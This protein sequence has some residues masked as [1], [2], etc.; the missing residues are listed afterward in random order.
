LVILDDPLAHTDPERHQRMLELLRETTERLQLIILTCRPDNYAE[1]GARGYNLE[2][3][4]T[5]LLPNFR[6]EH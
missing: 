1:L 2:E 3:L 5:C 6:K 4:K